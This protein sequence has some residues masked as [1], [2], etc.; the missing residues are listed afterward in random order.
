MTP[1]RDIDMGQHWLRQQ[2]ITWTNVDLS[3]VFSD[4]HLKA[5]YK[6]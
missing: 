1:Y 2:A 5:I 3:S 4:I 6:R